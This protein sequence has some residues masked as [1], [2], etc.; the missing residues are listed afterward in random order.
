MW[1]FFLALLVPTLP[2]ALAGSAIGLVFGIAH[3]PSFFSAHQEV[4]VVLIVAAFL[5]ALF[6]HWVGKRL[7]A[8]IAATGSSFRFGN[9]QVQLDSR[10]LVVIAFFVLALALTGHFHELWA[11]GVLIEKGFYE[12][13]TASVVFFLV[14]GIGVT[15]L[16]LRNPEREPFSSRLSILFADAGQEELEYFR[17]QILGLAGRKAEVHWQT[18]GVHDNVY[19]AGKS[20]ARTAH[21]LLFV[22]RDAGPVLVHAHDRCIDHLHR[23][24]MSGSQR[25]HNPV[26]DAG[27]PPAN[28]AIVASRMGTVA[29][30]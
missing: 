14:L 23:R 13:W 18:I 20:A 1:G 28:E 6:V 15:L 10:F 4:L 7:T 9:Y 17:S 24:I 22:I 29:A 27:P 11:D 19:L 16:G 21:M 25:I 3:N 30:W 26:P 8:L 5:I 2:G 12:A